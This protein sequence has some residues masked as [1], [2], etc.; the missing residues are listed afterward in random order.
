MF[1]IE[2]EPEEEGE[3]PRTR[4]TTLSVKIDLELQKEAEE[5]FE[6]IGLDIQSAIKLFL[7][8]SILRDGLPFKIKRYPRVSEE[9]LNSNFILDNNEVIESDEPAIINDLY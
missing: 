1:E 9:A 8:Q 6:D 5:L 3:M 4:E 2:E 7:K